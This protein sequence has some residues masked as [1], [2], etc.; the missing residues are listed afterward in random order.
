METNTVLKD[1]TE[2]TEFKKNNEWL[3][4][5]VVQY[6]ENTQFST[7]E[8]AEKQITETPYENVNT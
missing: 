1:T 8:S 6:T 4:N 7:S 5:V 3:E 2:N